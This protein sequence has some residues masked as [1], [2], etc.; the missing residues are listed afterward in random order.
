MARKRYEVSE[1]ILQR[2][3]LTNPDK[4]GKYTYYNILIISYM[5]I[6][7]K[8]VFAFWQNKNSRP[9]ARACRGGHQ[10]ETDIKSVKAREYATP[11]CCFTPKFD[12]N[13][14]EVHIC[15]KRHGRI[16]NHICAA[17]G[18]RNGDYYAEY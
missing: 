6:F 2:G 17:A 15:R 14:D 18:R 8:G 13:M 3:I 1:E 10:H 4:I 7:F 11:S 9:Q 16:S 12:L 5:K